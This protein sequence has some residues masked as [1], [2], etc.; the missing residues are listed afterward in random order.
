[1]RTGS[2]ASHS[3]KL[4]VVEDFSVLG[5]IGLGNTARSA[6]LVLLYLY[7]DRQLPVKL[8]T[9]KDQHELFAEQFESY[10]NVI[11]QYCASYEKVVR[12]SDVIVS[13]ATVFDTEICSD[14]CFKESVLVVPI[15]TRGFTNCDL[16][17]DKVFADDEIM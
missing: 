12:D 10:P 16:F 2:A 8:K 1:M 13:A 7:P 4:F 3:I 6:L 14:D 15:H 5:F 11:F 9:Y 17:F